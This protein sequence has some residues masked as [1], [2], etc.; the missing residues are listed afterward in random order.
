MYNI[1]LYQ[2]SLLQLLPTISFL[3][4]R[5]VSRAIC[6]HL[7]RYISSQASDAASRETY[8]RIGKPSAFGSSAL[9]WQMVFVGHR[10]LDLGSPWNSSSETSMSARQQRLTGV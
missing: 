7:L 4:R 8:F 5:V 1:V 6:P 9:T 3:T 2:T 10:S